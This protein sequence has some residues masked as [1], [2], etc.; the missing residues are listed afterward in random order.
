M[1]PDD[2]VSAATMEPVALTRSVVAYDTWSVGSS[3]P[4]GVVV[5]M[6]VYMLFKAVQINEFELIRLN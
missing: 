1:S 3:T 5:I 4:A 6:V 2:C